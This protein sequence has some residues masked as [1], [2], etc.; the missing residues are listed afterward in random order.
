VAQTVT[1]STLVSV[2]VDPAGTVPTKP[3]EAMSRAIGAPMTL[4]LDRNAPSRP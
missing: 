4:W 1:L 2:G 3:A